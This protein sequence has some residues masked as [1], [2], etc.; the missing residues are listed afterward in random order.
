M[1]GI[2]ETKEA[3]KLVNEVSLFLVATFKDGMQMADIT[4][5]IGKLTGDAAFT[6]VMTDAYEGW[7]LVDDELADLSQ[8]EQRELAHL[9]VDMVYDTMAAV[10]AKPEPAE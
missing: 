3:L 4:A 9:G 1:A 6:Q 8:S 7:K 10:K 2:K 5:I